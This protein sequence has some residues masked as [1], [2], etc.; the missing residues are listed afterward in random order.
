M[1]EPSADVAAN[2]AADA[3]AGERL[4]REGRRTDGTAITAERLQGLQV[5]GRE[6]ACVHCHRPSGMGGAEGSQAVPP[7][8][9]ALLN[10]PGRPAAA[11]SGRLAAGL[12]R[13]APASVTRP[14][15]TPALLAR[16][17]TQGLGAGGQPLDTL[18]P[19]YRL[20][21]QDLRQLAAYLD[22]LDTTAAPGLADGVL[23]LATIV[24]ADTPANVQHASGDLLAACLSNRSP[25]I[26]APVTASGDNP[27]ARPPAWH[28]HRWTL[29]TDPSRWPAELAEWQ[30]RQPVFALIGG[31]SGADG[32]GPWQAVHRHC[33]AQGLPCILPNTVSVDDQL[34]SRWSVY[35]SR[36]VG[37]EASGMAEHLTLHAPPGAEGARRVHQIVPPDDEA[38][39]TGAAALRRHLAASG[40]PVIDHPADEPD[41][42][43]AAWLAT[44]GRDDAL[45]LWL[46]AAHLRRISTRHPAPATGALLLS[47]ELPGLDAQALAPAWRPAARMAHAY[48]PAER[49]LPRLLRN[50]GRLLASLGQQP[51]AT[52][53]LLRLQ[54]H[55]LSACEMTANAL[56]RMGSQ[57]GRAWFME[58]IESADEAAVATAYPRFTLGPGQRHG[59]QGIGLMRYASPDHQRLQPAG[60]WLTPP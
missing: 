31:A 56:R 37:L 19:R 35:F 58:L 9:G 54:G 43:R 29:G 32:R 23:H 59:A 48:E 1:D 52:P 12:Q 22:T 4:Y 27:P 53:A 40:W 26:A 49:Q 15:Y 14:G 36:G 7:I 25:P 6:A 51:A 5:S 33:E 39:A 42:V 17:L 47:G 10:A 38:A 2:A 30:R 60:E 21:E 44:L 46:D 50:T 11:R 55:S 34:P 28:L 45:L 18:M 20:D 8:T 3:A 16:A 57:A 41:A 24:T 13:Q